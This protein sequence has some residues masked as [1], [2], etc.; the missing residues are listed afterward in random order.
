MA[1][2]IRKA[3]KFRRNPSLCEEVLSTPSKPYGSPVGD[4]IGQHRQIWVVNQMPVLLS[5]ERSGVPHVTNQTVPPVR[6]PRSV[7]KPPGHT[8]DE[9]RHRERLESKQRSAQERA[10]TRRFEISLTNLVGGRLVKASE[11]ITDHH[12]RTFPESNG[13]QC[14]CRGLL[15]SRHSAQSDIS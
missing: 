12:K 7:G 6:G 8:A 14:C 11:E 5:G 4:E 10:G 1:P 2:M 15:C 9:R 13:S 3:A